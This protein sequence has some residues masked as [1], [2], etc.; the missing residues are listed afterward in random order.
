MIKFL[1]YKLNIIIPRQIIVI[2]NSLL[3]ILQNNIYL[4]IM[5]NN[6]AHSYSYLYV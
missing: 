1:K 5:S 3:Y 6:G 2:L 4:L